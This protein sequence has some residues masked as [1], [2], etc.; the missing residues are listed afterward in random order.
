MGSLKLTLVE[1]QNRPV[2]LMGFMNFP[3]WT[4]PREDLVRA[5]SGGELPA[6][7]AARAAG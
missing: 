6:A 5:L 3:G 4:R 2:C 7:A 1:G